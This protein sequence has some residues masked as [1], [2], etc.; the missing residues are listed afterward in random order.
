M[1]EIPYSGKPRSRKSNQGGMMK[2]FIIAVCTLTVLASFAF[3]G[4]ER[5]SSGKEMKQTAVQKAPCHTW[6]RG[7]EWN[8]SLCGSYAFTGNDCRNDRYLGVDHACG[9]SI[10]AKDVYT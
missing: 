3:G 2:K 6:Y 8:S 4:T 9:G 5:Y 7:T 10:D 1:N